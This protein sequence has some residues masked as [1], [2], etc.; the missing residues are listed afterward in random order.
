MDLDLHL[1]CNSTGLRCNDTGLRG[2]NIDMLFFG[3]LC[4]VGNLAE[5]LLISARSKRFQDF[6]EIDE[7]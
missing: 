6:P 3:P 7:F 4:L 2:D 5:I 1:I